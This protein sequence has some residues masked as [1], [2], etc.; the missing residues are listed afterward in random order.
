MNMTCSRIIEK[1]KLLFEYTQEG[2]KEE[3]TTALVTLLVVLLFVG[4][5][6]SKSMAQNDSCQSVATMH[7]QIRSLTLDEINDSSLNITLLHSKLFFTCGYDFALSSNFYARMNIGAAYVPHKWGGYL[8]GGVDFN[9]KPH[10]VAGGIYRFSSEKSVMD[11]QAY[12]G[13]GYGPRLGVETGVRLSAPVFFSS[14]VPSILHISA[15]VGYDGEHPYGSVNLGIIE[16]QVCSV[17]LFCVLL[18][19]GYAMDYE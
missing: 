19:C 3:W 11:W 7:N 1:N 2:T 12:G 15:G 14:W 6:H 18:M 17:V 5:F 9:N 8:K 13:V 16:A 4:C 10:F